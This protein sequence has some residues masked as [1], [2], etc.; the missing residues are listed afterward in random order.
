MGRVAVRLAMQRHMLIA[1]LAV[2]L[3]GVAPAV[4]ADATSTVN[5]AAPADQSTA[6]QKSANAPNSPQP[7]ADTFAN[8]EEEFQQDIG[9]QRKLVWATVFLVVVGILQA[10]ILVV[11]A[12]AFWLTLRAVRNQADL[13]GVHA[14]HLGTLAKVAEDTAAAAKANAEA[15]RDG[16]EAT[17]QSIEL[18]ISKERARITVKPS[19]LKLPRPEELFGL[20]EMT[21]K[22]FCYGTTPAYI[23]QSSATLS[24]TASEEPLESELQITP[25]LL[26][27][28]V[29]PNFEGIDKTA[30]LMQNVEPD[31]ADSVAQRKM[32][33]HFRGLIRYKDAFGKERETRFRYVWR[34]TEMKNLDGSPFAFWISSGSWS[35][36]Q[37]T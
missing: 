1:S 12:I 21:Y 14:G 7:V 16:A 36:N 31:I 2:M 8:R 23:D 15:A 28:A 10:V 30:L 20:G 29:Q 25:M 9:I 13:M 37:E 6:D 3:C 11:Q 24:L 4:A 5:R 27:P 17:K 33:A 32:F 19:T 35:D 34:V 18:L 26:G 22:V